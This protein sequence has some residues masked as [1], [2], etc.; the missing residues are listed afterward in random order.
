[1][2]LRF[3]EDN[4]PNRLLS[5][6]GQDFCEVIQIDAVPILLLGGLQQQHTQGAAVAL[7]V[8]TSRA[9]VGSSQS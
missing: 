7:G 2:L 3:G 9:I 6:F 5:L 4:R 1:M 8:L